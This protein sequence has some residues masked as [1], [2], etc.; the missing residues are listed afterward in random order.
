MTLDIKALEPLFTRLRLR[1]MYEQFKVLNDDPATIDLPLVEVMFILASTEVN[2]R[3]ERALQRRVTEA[4]LCHPAA[5]VQDV[6]YAP[7]RKLNRKQIETLAT[8]DW[9][10]NHQNCI[11]TGKA[12]CGKTWLADAL[13]HAAC[14]AGFK[15]KFY[16]LSDLLVELRAEIKTGIGNIRD[17]LKKI[18]VLIID[19]WGTVGLDHQTRTGLLDIINDRRG[20]GSTI[21]TSVMPVDVWAVYIKDPTIADSLLDRL[22]HNAHRIEVA[23][24]SLR[25]QEKYGAVS[26]SYESLA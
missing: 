19:D 8:C 1:T 2:R 7:E 14:Q 18:D 4:C 21:I 26:N 10:R 25:G 16:R 3:D 20:K 6:D 17:Y 9:I 13:G 15:V 22:V 24:A 5:C 12:G 11:I 23:G